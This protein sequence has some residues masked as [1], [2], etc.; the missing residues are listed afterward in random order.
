MNAPVS[1]LHSYPEPAP[2][3][4]ENDGDGSALGF[5]GWLSIDGASSNVTEPL[6]AA[7]L[8]EWYTA[9]TMYVYGVPAVAL[10]SVHDSPVVS[11]GEPQIVAP[12]ERE[13]W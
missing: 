4:N 9:V 8:K 10:E 1:S 6:W 11:V 3:L 13:T 5:D 2:P 12:S 7:A